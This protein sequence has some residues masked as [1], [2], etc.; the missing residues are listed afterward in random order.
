[1]QLSDL[2]VRLDRDS[3]RQKPCCQNVALIYP[4]KPPHARELRCERCGAFR[5]WASKALIEF[6]ETTRR[7]FGAP[8]EPIVWRQ[9]QQEQTMEYD[10]TNRGALFRNEDKTE[11][12]HPDYRGSLNVDG[13]ELWLSAWI[14][15]SKKGT[16]YMSLSVKPKQAA[17]GRSKS[18]AEDLNDSVGF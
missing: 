5:G 11:E 17:V 3:D 12:N 8:A 9:E 6:L 13:T 7:R 15:T 2:R 14:K 1:M 16:K 10:N 4:G 18:R